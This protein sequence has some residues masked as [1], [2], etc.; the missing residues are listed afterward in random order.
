MHPTHPL[1]AL[2][3]MTSLACTLPAQ[4]NDDQAKAVEAFRK[5]AQ[6]CKAAPAQPDIGFELKPIAGKTAAEQPATP[7]ELERVKRL[8]TQANMPFDTVNHRVSF[9]FTLALVRVKKVA[10]FK[11]PEGDAKQAA[12]MRDCLKKLATEVGL[13]SRF[14]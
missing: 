8:L 1:R 5:E 13:E 10:S 6:T 3:L 12:S 9:E 4:A 7:E 11:L 2:L 14:E